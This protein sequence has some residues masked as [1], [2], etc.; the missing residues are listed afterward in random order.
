MLSTI[1]A[2]ILANARK[3]SMWIWTLLFP[4]I[5]S[6]MFIFMFSSLKNSQSVDPVPVAVVEDDAWET[7]GFS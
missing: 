6:T 3:P 4:I 1:K 2:T 5:L 7:S